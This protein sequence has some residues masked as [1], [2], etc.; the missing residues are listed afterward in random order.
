M[1]RAKEAESCR[2]KSMIAPP[3]TPL[4]HRGT[5]DCPLLDAAGGR[6]VYRPGD[7]VDRS[8]RLVSR[9]D[10]VRVGGPSVVYHSE[11]GMLGLGLHGSVAAATG[12]HCDLGSGHICQRSGSSGDSICF[13]QAL[14]SSGG[15]R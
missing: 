9:S 3:R 1:W 10:L 11:K 13:D 7:S 5:P 4:D 6:A 14:P 8:E 2:V 15:Q 12:Q